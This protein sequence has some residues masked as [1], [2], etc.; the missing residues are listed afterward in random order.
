[1]GVRKD[2]RILLLGEPKVGKT[3]LIMT[4]VSEE[5]PEEVPHRAEEITIPAD[6]TPEKV[7]THIVDYSDIEQT[8]EELQEEILRAHVVCVVYAVDDQD[9]IE[10]ITSKWVP[11]IIET[12]GKDGRIPII[13]VGNKTDLVEQSSMEAILPIMNQYS[14]IEACVECSAR[15]LRNISEV[16]YYAQ[17][18][19][20]HPTGPLYSPEE[21]QLRPGCVKAL[22]RIFRISDQ[23]ND[24]LLN[25]TEINYFQKTCYKSPLAPHT[26]E[27]VKNVVRK[28]TTNGVLAGALTLEGFL[29]L[30]TLFVQRGRHETTWTALR[31]FGYDE[32][33]DLT[34]EYLYP[35]LKVPSDCTTE[36]NHHA[37]N[38][39][40]RI[41]EKHD[42]DR[43]GALSLEELKELFG[44]FPYMPWGPDV[45]HTVLTNE[46]GWIT[47]QGYLAQW[48]LTAYLDVHRCLEYLGHLGYPLLADQPSQASAITVTRDK[49]LDL[50][51]K[52]T[53]RNAF[54]C[55]VFG[56]R[57]AGKSAFLQA[58][59]GKNLSRQKR[60]R[61]EH[62]SLYAINALS[63]Y[64]HDKYLLMHE[65][66]TDSEFLASGDVR[67]DVACL[68]YNVDDPHSFEYC[69]RIFK[70]HFLDSRV[71]CVV[72][73]TKSDLGAVKQLHGLSPTEFCRKHR[74]PL[75]APFTPG[76]GDA[77]TPCRDIFLKLLTVAI[78]PHSQ[79]DCL[80]NCNKCTLCVCQNLL[81]SALLRGLRSRLL[82]SLRSRLWDCLEELGVIVLS[83]GERRGPPHQVHA[84]A[85]G[86]GSAFLGVSLPR[87]HWRECE[88]RGSSVWLRASI[89]A[90]MIALLGLGVYRALVRTQR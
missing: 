68:L 83:S 30:H 20:L 77:E 65:I 78:Y 17:K 55:N 11:L 80:C 56:V 35:S 60:I 58:F 90:A 82:A 3:S 45:N 50:T 22:T 40:Q 4:L 57:G 62:R 73:A 84:V 63:I 53:Q 34:D 31:R 27:D 15:V 13:L 51:K 46:R 25:D 1:M 59:L 19:V 2:V 10:K 36:L 71:P 29:F 37:Y 66:D 7:P 70:Q 85:L 86:E 5:F 14:D 39:L 38:F 33:L 69:A 72:V 54:L 44:V 88:A 47:Q 67:C 81:G 24:G 9:S 52:Q 87:R 6:V 89:G 16:F 64:G 75:P 18:A 49:K 8:D 12:V 48:T 41:F 28:N 26:L 74:L 79:L 61:E 23:D 76:V 32:G 21:K 42:L 43:D